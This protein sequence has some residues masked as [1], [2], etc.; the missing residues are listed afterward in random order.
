MKGRDFLEVIA[1][2]IEMYFEEVGL[3]HVDYICL[4]VNGGSDGVF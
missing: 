2:N 3:E 1:I 4:A